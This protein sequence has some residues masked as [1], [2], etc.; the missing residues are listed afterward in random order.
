MNFYFVFSNTIGKMIILS[1]RTVCS[2]G[3]ILK[4][5]T[6]NF[7]GGRIPTMVN[8]EISHPNAWV[9]VTSPILLQTNRHSIPTIVNQP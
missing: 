6:F 8:C 5:L 9:I 1:Y 3:I 4:K 7:L 2:P